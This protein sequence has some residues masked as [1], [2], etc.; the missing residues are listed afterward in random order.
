MGNNRNAVMHELYEI[1]PPSLRIGKYL[2][3]ESKIVGVKNA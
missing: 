2:K 3:A 1:P